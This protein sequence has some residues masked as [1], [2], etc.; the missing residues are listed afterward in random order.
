MSLSDVF[1]Y[2][3]LSTLAGGLSCIIILVI[4]LVILLVVVSIID[5]KI[6]KPEYLRREKEND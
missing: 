6:I 3:F 4:M 2:V 1:S 5:R